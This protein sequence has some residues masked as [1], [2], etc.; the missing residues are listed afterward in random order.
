MYENDFN[1]VVRNSLFEGF[2]IPDTYF[3]TGGKTG[4]S[5]FDGLGIY[6]EE[7]G[8][9]TVYSPLYWESKYNREAGAFNLNRVE[10][11]QAVALSRYGLIKNAKVWLIYG[12]NVARNDHRV[13]V[14]DWR[15]VEALYLNGHSFHMK[16]LDKLPHNYIKKSLTTFDKIVTRADIVD[17]FGEG[18]YTCQKP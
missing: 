17:V 10:E 13:Y 14:F 2:K 6:R 11:H 8:E 15:A 18:V 9:E 3:N 12:V 5:P 16:H 7:I 1:S 4:K